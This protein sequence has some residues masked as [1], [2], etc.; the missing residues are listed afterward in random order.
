MRPGTRLHWTG[1][2]C[3]PTDLSQRPAA[4][5]PLPRTACPAGPPA[6][7]L[8]P[9]PEVEVPSPGPQGAW[10]PLRVASSQH[11]I[12]RPPSSFVWAGI[13]AWGGGGRTGVG[14][15]SHLWGTEEGG[16]IPFTSP[17]ILPAGVS[18]P[19]CFFLRSS[20][21]FSFF[22]FL[23]CLFDSLIHHTDSHTSPVCPLSPSPPAPSSPSP[24]SSLPF[25]LLY[26]S[27]SLFL[28]PALPSSL[29]ADNEN[30]F[31]LTLPLTLGCSIYTIWSSAP[32][33]GTARDGVARIKGG[34]TRGARPA[35]CPGWAS[36]LPGS[37]TSG[38]LA[39][40]LCWPALSDPPA[41][42]LL[43]FFPPPT[44]AQIQVQIACIE[45]FRNVG[46]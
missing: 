30:V 45:L 12:G 19:H 16:A 15:L 27:F 14:W 38:G 43:L 3:S 4:P 26:F 41:P 25:P 39:A 32:C 44:S 8:L 28:P 17:R 2:C 31:C 37:L 10:P 6:G 24:T 13:W 7:A 46:T 40:S 5:G 21:S 34:G 29:K 33:S 1:A 18:P 11:R 35:G 9:L 42:P 22:P 36:A 20:L 23:F